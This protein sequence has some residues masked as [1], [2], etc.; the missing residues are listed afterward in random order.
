MPK[1]FERNRRVAQ[2]LKKKLAVL[3]QEKFPLKQYGLM[4]LTNVDVSSDLK[5]STIYFTSLN[6]KWSNLELVRKLNEQASYF[7][8]EIS[9][10]LTS[11]TVPSLCFRHDQSIERAQRISNIIESISNQNEE[12]GKTENKY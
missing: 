1:E 10:L 7:R 8:Y 12:N 11:K 5:N 6:S 2:L 3:I 9:Q 4:T